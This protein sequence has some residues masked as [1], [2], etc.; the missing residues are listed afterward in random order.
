MYLLKAVGSDPEFFL[1]DGK[2]KFIPACGL[3]GGSKE[4]PQF[5]NKDGFSAVLEDNVMVEFNTKPARNRYE[6][7]QHVY[8]AMNHAI[9]IAEQKGLL[10]SITPSAVFSPEFLCSSQA[11]EIGCLG[12][13]NAWTG[14]ANPRQTAADLGLVRVAGG[15]LHISYEFNGEMPDKQDREKLIRYLDLGLG[16][17]FTWMD[18]DDTRRRFYGKAGA[19]R[20]KDYGVEYRT[21]SNYWLRDERLMDFVF[22]QI[23]WTFNVLN[24]GM[25]MEPAIERMVQQA[26]NLPDRGV[27]EELCS[28]FNIK[29]P[30][31]GGAHP[32]TPLGQRR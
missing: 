3:I 10:A 6:F 23:E 30:D 4:E 22:D 15:H 32:I 18:R 31:L 28:E 14:E 17:P 25:A 8:L 16:V 20:A 12:D 24:M 21:L 1:E 11:Q 5:F 29:I 9:S 2:G 27:V 26:I 19:Y 7:S 13:N